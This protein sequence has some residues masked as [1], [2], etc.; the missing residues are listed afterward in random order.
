[1]CLLLYI[2]MNDLLQNPCFHFNTGQSN[3]VV[4]KKIFTFYGTDGQIITDYLELRIILFI[5]KIV[6]V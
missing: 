3:C 4:N 6:L 1:M 2:V 5:Q